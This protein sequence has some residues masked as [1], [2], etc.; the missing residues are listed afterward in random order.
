MTLAQCCNDMAAEVY[1]ALMKYSVVYTQEFGHVFAYEIDGFG[2]HLLMDDAN[3]PSLLSLPYLCPELVDVSDTIY[4]NTRRMVWSEANPY[5]FGGGVQ[6]LESGVR[7]IGSQHT[8][9]NMVWPMSIIMKGLTSDDVLEQRECVSMLM[10]TD[11]GTGFM[12]ESFLPSNPNTFTRSWF[13]WVNGLFA[14][15]VLKAYGE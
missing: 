3:V 13:S 1:D 9:L 8:G 5:F 11:A 4:Q 2:S 10:Q 6:G 7:G 14:E 15:L 12:H